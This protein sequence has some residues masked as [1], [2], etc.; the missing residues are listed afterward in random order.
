M[1][2]S[3]K[4]LTIFTTRIRRLTG[5]YIF[6][7]STLAGG[8]G[9]PV[10]G[11]GRGWGTPSQVWVKGYPIPGLGGG[12]PISGLGGTPSQVWMVGGV[13]HP[14]LDGGGGV[15][16]PGLDGGGE[17]PGVPHHHPDLA[18]VQTFYT[19]KIL[20]TTRKSSCVN[21]RGILPNT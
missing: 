19:K 10:S 1:M 20:F 7:L 13:P 12:Y 2:C 18:G 3:I 15:P 17:V 14:G 5:G 21:A 11:L 9:Y 8:G 4:S 6:T 16:Q